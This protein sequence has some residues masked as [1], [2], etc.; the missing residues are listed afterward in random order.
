MNLIIVA[1]WRKLLQIRELMA[2]IY[3]HIYVEYAAKEI[4]HFN[5][6]CC[7]AILMTIRRFV[8]RH[9]SS[10][11]VSNRFAWLPYLIVFHSHGHCFHLSSSLFFVS[12]WVNMFSF[13]KY[14]W[15][16]DLI[17]S[18]M[19]NAGEDIASNLFRKFII[20]P[21][22]TLSLGYRG[23]IKGLLSSEQITFYQN[24]SILCIKPNVH[25]RTA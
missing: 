8:G 19:V 2:G 7:P 4:F 1:L 3:A 18:P 13:E 6:Q 11:C 10:L 9:C 12:D 24:S 22:N 16:K 17:K 14:V 25:S 20:N 21:Y 15:K 5:L 23:Q